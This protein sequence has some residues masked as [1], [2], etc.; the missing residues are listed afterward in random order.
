MCCFFFFFVTTTKQFIEEQ[1][2]ISV[3]FEYIY[4]KI[5]KKTYFSI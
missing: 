3:E 2:D 5:I 4:F 1:F